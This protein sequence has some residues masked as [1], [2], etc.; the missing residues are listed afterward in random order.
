MTENKVIIMTLLMITNYPKCI[1]GITLDTQFSGVTGAFPR[2][3]GR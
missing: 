1:R 2:F 3:W